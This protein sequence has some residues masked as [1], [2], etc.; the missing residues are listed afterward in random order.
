MQDSL[1]SFRWTY[2]FESDGAII[3]SDSTLRFSSYEEISNSLKD[4]G[5]TLEEVRDAPDRPGREL[6]F[7]ARRPTA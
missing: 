5:L 6:V 4:V 1:V 3:T 2:V 7:I